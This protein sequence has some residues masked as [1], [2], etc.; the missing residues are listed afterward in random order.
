MLHEVALAVAEASPNAAAAQD[1]PGSWQNQMGST[2]QFTIS[3]PI[4]SGT[5]TS[6]QSG[7]GGPVTG[8]LQGYVAGNLI[9]FQVLWPSGSITAWVGHLFQPSGS[10]PVIKT[11]WHLVTEIPNP[12]DPNDFWQ[13]VLAGADEFVAVGGRPF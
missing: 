8:Q 5:Y 1:I 7:G 2:M 4:L 6:A 3:A 12:S 9:S 13:S 10:Q 11:L